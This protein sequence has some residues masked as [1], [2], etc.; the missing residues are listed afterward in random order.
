MSITITIDPGHYG[1]TYNPGVVPGYYESE[2]VW[3]LHL[4]LVKEF[5]ALGI[6]VKTTRKNIDENPALYDRG[7]SAKGTDLFISVHTNAVGKYT[8]ETELVDRAE[9]ITGLDHKETYSELANAVGENIRNVMGT[10][11]NYITYTRESEEKKGIE[12]Y[13]VLRGA[14]GAG[15]I[16]RMIIEHSYHTC[17]RTCNWLLNETNLAYLAKTEAAVIAN[18]LKSVEPKPI[19]EDYKEWEGITLEDVNMRVYPVSGSVIT[20]IAK[21]SKVKVLN[22]YL[23]SVGYIWYKIQYGSFEGYVHS[24]YILPNQLEVK[25]VNTPELNVRIGPGV[26]YQNLPVMKLVFKGTKLNVLETIDNWCRVYIQ[27]TPSKVGYV[28]KDYLQ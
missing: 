12:W 6:N 19:R 25:I 3:K 18:Y 8:N 20:P 22:E 9:I 7:Y 16:R 15:V 24:A 26:S 5:E 27:D 1:H 13:G 28:K 10:R 11:Q 21:G 17:T 2:T 4:Y 14:Q 23:G